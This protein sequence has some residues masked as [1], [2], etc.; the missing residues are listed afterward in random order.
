MT[1][2]ELRQLLQRRLL[3]LLAGGATIEV[4][5]A[6]RVVFREVV[7]RAFRLEL[8]GEQAALAL[9]FRPVGIPEWEPRLGTD[10]YPIERAR[11]LLVDRV[12]DEADGLS[13]DGPTGRTRIT[14]LVDRADVERF[15]GWQSFRE[16]WLTREE[17]DSL[18]ELRA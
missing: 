17:E 5:E 13:L 3:E 15:S 7:D 9:W 6:D 1:R 2:A 14:P 12:A 11:C 8:S 4:Y 18:D 16:I 10:A